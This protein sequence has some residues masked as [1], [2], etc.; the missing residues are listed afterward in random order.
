MGVDVAVPVA[1]EVGVRVAGG[2]YG[3]S[4]DVGE[5]GTG[6]L[7]VVPVGVDVAGGGYAPGAGVG[8]GGTGVFVNVAADAIDAILAE[9]TSSPVRSTALRARATEVGK[10]VWGGVGAGASAGIVIEM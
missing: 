10:D 2:G 7:V 5:G 9:A 4:V 8:D 1:V 3:S 6:V